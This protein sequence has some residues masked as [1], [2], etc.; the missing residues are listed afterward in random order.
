M[1][2]SDKILKKKRKNVE[3]RD[4]F[5]EIRIC[6]SALPRIEHSRTGKNRTFLNSGMNYPGGDAIRIRLMASDR[7]SDG[8]IWMATDMGNTSKFM[9]SRG[10]D[11]HDDLHGNLFNRIIADHGVKCGD[12]D[13][14]WK[15]CE[16][17]NFD[18][19]SLDMLKAVVNLMPFCGPLSCLED[20]P[21]EKEHAESSD[22][23]RGPR[24]T[25]P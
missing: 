11:I 8:H 23:R 16:P 24:T 2:L 25:L 19:A 3:R 9:K 17:C 1:W 15:P 6:G 21:E 14:L 5:D 7:V 18:V 4:P 20:L 10:I 13:V 12:D 22:L